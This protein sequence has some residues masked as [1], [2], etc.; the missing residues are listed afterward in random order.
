M[1]EKEKKKDSKDGM[2]KRALKSVRK[3]ETMKEKKPADVSSLPKEMKPVK[4][5]F[6]IIKMVSMTEK[7][8]Q[9]IEI[10]NKLVFIVDKKSSKN[11]IKKSV[12]DAFQTK[13]KGVETL[14]DKK[15][16]KKAFVKLKDA[17]AAGEI[18]I[19][20]GII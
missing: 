1:K 4:D 3:K 18:A 7:S 13:V 19:R 6:S 17:G 2:I 20:L 10:Q 9:M 5:P 16:R 14:I 11:D 15:G 8:I 12:E